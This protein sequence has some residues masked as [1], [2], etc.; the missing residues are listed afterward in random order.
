MAIVVLLYMFDKILFAIEDVRRAVLLGA[1]L[2]MVRAMNVLW[3]VRT[4]LA[5]H[6]VAPILA[7]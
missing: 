2:P 3:P 5:P 4:V 6:V 1:A 7:G